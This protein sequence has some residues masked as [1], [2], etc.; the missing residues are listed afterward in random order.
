[1]VFLFVELLQNDNYKNLLIVEFRF[2]V[3][4]MLHR[5]VKR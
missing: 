5:V 3:L 1:M 2:I 4:F